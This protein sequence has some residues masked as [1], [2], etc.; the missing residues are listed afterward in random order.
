MNRVHLVFS[1]GFW[2]RLA[3]ETF[4]D[5]IAPAVISE[6]NSY[7]LFSVLAG[8]A[9]LFDLIPRLI[10]IISVNKSLLEGVYFTALKLR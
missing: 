9:V 8:S 7:L 6:K 1:A 5:Q 2:A 4:T 3:L 10:L